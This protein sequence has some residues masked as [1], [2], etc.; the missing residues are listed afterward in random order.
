M[1]EPMLNKEK[2]NN[3]LLAYFLYA[4]NFFFCFFVKYH[5][6][7]QKKKKCKGE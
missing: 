4:N 5:S 2:H 7:F 1:L 3:I 6:V